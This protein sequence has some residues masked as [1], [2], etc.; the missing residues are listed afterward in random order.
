MYILIYE[1]GDV[2]KSPDFSDESKELC[3]MGILSCIDIGDAEPL[4][5]YDD[6]WHPLES[7]E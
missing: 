2:K 3:D 1:D 7:A 4:D 5:Y 6:D